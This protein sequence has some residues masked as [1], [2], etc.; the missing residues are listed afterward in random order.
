VYDQVNYLTE[1]NSFFFNLDTFPREDVEVFGNV[2]YYTGTAGSSDIGL[3]SS[4]LVKQ[5]GGMDYDLF[6]DV[7]PGFSDLDVNWLILTLGTNYQLNDRWVINGM[8]GYNDYVDNDPYLFDTTGSR[9]F[10]QLGAAFIF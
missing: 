5:P 1:T 4:N 7:V 8:G 9:F 6:N 2:L 10:L 3:D